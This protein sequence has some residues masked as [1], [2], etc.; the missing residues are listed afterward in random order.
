[1]AKHIIVPSQATKKDL[2]DLFKVKGE[3]I[4]VIPHGV[5]VSSSI[6]VDLFDC[7][8]GESREPRPSAVG[9]DFHR[10]DGS[11]KYLLFLGTI[12][13]RK[14]VSTIVRAYRMM[15]DRHPELKEVELRLAGAVGWRANEIVDAIRQTQCEGYRISLVGEISED[16]KWELLAGASG[17]L[18]P[19]LYE[20]FGLP[21]AEALAVGVPVICADNSSLSEVAGGAAILVGATKV[22]GWAEK[23]TK[24]LTDEKTADE[25]RAKGL[26]RGKDFSWAHAAEETL[27]V[28]RRLSAGR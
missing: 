15:V 9:P 4:S 2:M 16:D 14:N 27:K 21:V 11:A 3:K 7:H 25:L 24:I 18:F 1:L 26:E 10:G 13:P 28:Y 20:G 17:F 12:E 8:P 6:E 23:M 5:S 19:S 22:E